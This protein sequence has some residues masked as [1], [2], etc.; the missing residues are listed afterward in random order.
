MLKAESRYPQ[1][2]L[3]TTAIDSAL[4]R[5]QNYLVGAP[6]IFIITDHKP[7]CPIF[8]SYMKISIRTDRIKLYHQE[9]NYAVQ[10]QQRKANQSDYLP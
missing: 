8:N 5:F 4:C 3:E 2:D 9:I 7:L 1:L 6:K 10:Y